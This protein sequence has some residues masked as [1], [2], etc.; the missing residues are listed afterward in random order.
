MGGYE[1][2]NYSS[3]R[4]RKRA[5]GSLLWDSK[6]TAVPA[7]DITVSAQV[8][9]TKSL[10]IGEDADVSAFYTQ[11]FM[12]LQQNS[13]KVIAKAFVK[14]IEPKK[15]TK[16]PYTGGSERAPSWWPPRPPGGTRATAKEGFVRHKEPD[17][18]MKTGK[19]LSRYL[20]VLGLS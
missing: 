6:Y 16:H 4:A 20:M 11:R 15:Q 19:N 8:Q 13:C 17:H 3:A 18:L 14:A 12:D 7:G 10:S 9:K 5:R 2:E 1:D